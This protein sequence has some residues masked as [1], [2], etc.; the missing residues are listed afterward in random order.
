MGLVVAIIIIA[1]LIIAS[2]SAPRRSRASSRAPSDRRPWIQDRAEPLPPST[3]RVRKTR[4]A[5]DAPVFIIYPAAQSSPAAG[6]PGP[7]AA[8]DGLRSEAGPGAPS[9]P[10]GDRRSDQAAHASPVSLAGAAWLTASDDVDEDYEAFVAATWG[11]PEAID[12][13]VTLERITYDGRATTSELRSLV[14][15]RDGDFYVN[16]VE[17]GSRKTYVAGRYKWRRAGQSVDS[18]AFK[19]IRAGVNPERALRWVPYPR[20]AAEALAPENNHVG[21]IGRAFVIGYRDS[22]GETSYRVV[23]SVR[24]SADGFSAHC[25]FRWGELRHFLYARLLSVADAETGEV[26]PLEVFADRARPLA[27]GKARTKARG[28]G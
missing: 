2:R 25:H 5:I 8:S 27:G 7:L 21:A 9:P 22:R 20:S 11:S 12:A 15:R 16:T 6:R 23:S 24:R 14:P 1:F 3:S 10:G 18:S 28:G 4:R 17:G 26:I 19:A 13:R